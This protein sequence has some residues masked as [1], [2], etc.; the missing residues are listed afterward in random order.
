MNQTKTAAK[1]TQNRNE[2]AAGNSFLHR[3][4]RRKADSLSRANGFGLGP[5]DR[6][7]DRVPDVLTGTRRMIR[8]RWRRCQRRH[9]CGVVRECGGRADLAGSAELDVPPRLSGCPDLNWGPLR[10]ERSA[11]PGCAT[12]RK[13]AYSVDEGRIRHAVRL[14]CGHELVRRSEGRVKILPGA[15][16]ELRQPGPPA[17]SAAGFFV[18]IENT[19]DREERHWPTT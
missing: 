10:P 13:S 14:S 9:S 3:R 8:R 18:R 2:I 6:V 16:T 15:A 4:R 19:N 17:L 7:P 11:L 1:G 12:P 5:P